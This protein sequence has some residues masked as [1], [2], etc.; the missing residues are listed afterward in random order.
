MPITVADL[1][2][3]QGPVEKVFF[4]GE[5]VPSDVNPALTKLEVRLTTYIDRAYAKAAEV[6]FVGT[7]QDDPAGTSLYPSRSTRLTF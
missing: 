6:G 2:A 1:L 4:E 5:D 7:D 3:P